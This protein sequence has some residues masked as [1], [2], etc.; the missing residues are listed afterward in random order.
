M[1]EGLFVRRTKSPSLG[2][3][4][5]GEKHTT[6]MRNRGVS[7]GGSSLETKLAS[8]SDVHMGD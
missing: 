1:I 3:A 7:R 4:V 5:S 8:G 6:V 2:L